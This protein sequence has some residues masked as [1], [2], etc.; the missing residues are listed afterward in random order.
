MPKIQTYRVEWTIDIEATSPEEAAKKALEIQ[1][2]ENS[3]ADHFTVFDE[4][5]DSTDLDV[6]DIE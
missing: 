6:S 4:A 1:R 3:T 5:G 2:D